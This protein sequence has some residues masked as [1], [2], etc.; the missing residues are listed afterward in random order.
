[1]NGRRRVWVEEVQ[2]GVEGRGKSRRLHELLTLHKRLASLCARS[3]SPRLAA[4]GGM[5]AVRQ[6]RP[7]NFSLPLPLRNGLGEGMGAKAGLP[8]E[9]R[10]LWWRG[11]EALLAV[12]WAL[13]S[14]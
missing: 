5:T 2:R 11:G 4:Y 7:T 9:N 14:K 1:M 12:Q 3:S 6:C 8:L 13:V 10:R